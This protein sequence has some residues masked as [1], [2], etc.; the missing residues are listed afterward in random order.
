MDS[1]DRY[2]PVKESRP[3]LASSGWDLWTVTSLERNV[4]LTTPQIDRLFGPSVTGEGKSGWPNL[5][6]NAS[7]DHHGLA[8]AS[9]EL[10]HS[11]VSSLWGMSAWPTVNEWTLL[12]SHFPGK[13]SR[14]VLFGPSLLGEECRPDSALRWIGSF[15]CHFLWRKVGLTPPEMDRLFGQSLRGEGESTWPRL[16]P[17]V[18]LDSHF[19]GKESQPDHASD[20]TSNWTVSSQGG[21]SARAPQMNGLCLCAWT[22]ALIVQKICKTETDYLDYWLRY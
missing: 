18:C 2:F 5:R 21:I 22:T 19:P 1:L 17:N 9:D 4:D 7:L 10:T 11:T 12:D 3:D 13:E 8:P 14:P 16:R 6:W 15:D 20:E